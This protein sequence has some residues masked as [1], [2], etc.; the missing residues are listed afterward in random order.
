MIIL[1]LAKSLQFVWLVTKAD[2]SVTQ[3]IDFQPS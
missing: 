1:L 2:S 3:L